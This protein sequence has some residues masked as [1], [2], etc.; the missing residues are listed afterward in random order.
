ML[1]NK[2]RQLAVELVNFWNGQNGHLAL[3]LA[4]EASNINADTT[5]VPLKL[6]SKNEIVEKPVTGFCGLH[7]Q[8]VLKV[9]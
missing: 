6:T 3:L 9:V 5:N 4:M 2:T 7:G 1:W 8:A